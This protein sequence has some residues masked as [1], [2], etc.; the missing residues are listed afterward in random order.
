MSTSFDCVCRSLPEIL[1]PFNFQ[2]NHYFGGLPSLMVFMEASSLTCLNSSVALCAPYPHG[3]RAHP[4][5]ASASMSEY[6]RS[7]GRLPSGV[8]VLPSSLHWHTQ[9]SGVRSFKSLARH[10]ASPVFLT[11]V[12]GTARGC[13]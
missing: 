11:L 2:G 7:P 1:F 12:C 5:P 6:P 10:A 4:E 9:A 3:E 13:P 8:L